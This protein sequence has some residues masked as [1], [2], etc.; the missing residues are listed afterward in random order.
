MAGELLIQTVDLAALEQALP[1]LDALDAGRPLDAAGGRLIDALL[2]ASTVERA[3]PA[4]RIQILRRIRRHPALAPRWF[5]APSEIDAAVD[6]VLDGVV[7]AEGGAW[8]LSGP[9]GE[10]WVVLEGAIPDM[11]AVDALEQAFF[12]VDGLDQALP[13]P[14]RGE[15][16]RS[17]VARDALPRLAEAARR[18]AATAV[19][20]IQAESRGLARVVDRALH[21][22]DAA[23]AYA[24]LL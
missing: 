23:L 7:F 5:L 22:R 6:A 18:L 10:T 2:L 4:G 11:R 20:P 1:T 3:D 13:Y 16:Q 17:L 21:R 15:L 8:S 19:A 14:K 12:S 24:F 9:F